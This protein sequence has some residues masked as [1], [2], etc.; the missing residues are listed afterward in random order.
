MSVDDR[1]R[2]CATGGSDLF[3]DRVKWVEVPAG[4]AHGCAFGRELAGDGTP[5]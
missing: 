1:G 3:G 4:Q 2:R 5:D